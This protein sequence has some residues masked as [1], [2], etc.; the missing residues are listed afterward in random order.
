MPTE[1]IT[2]EPENVEIDGETHNFVEE[3]GFDRETNTYPW[4]KDRELKYLDEEVTQL[5]EGSLIPETRDKAIELVSI[6]FGVALKYLPDNFRDDNEV[7]KTARDNSA[8]QV[9]MKRI[10]TYTDDPTNESWRVIGGG[11]QEERWFAESREA[12]AR[13]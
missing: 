5:I 13:T 9:L 4:G 10:H 2:T 3:Y 6:R 11:D 8:W 7:I 12:L 1:T